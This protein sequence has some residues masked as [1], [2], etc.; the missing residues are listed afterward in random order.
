MT[1]EDALKASELISSVAELNDAAN[2]LIG[3]KPYGTVSFCQS[4]QR[5]S[6]PILKTSENDSKA[7]QEIEYKL[8]DAF[9]TF[10]VESIRILREKRDQLKTELENL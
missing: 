9:D 8:A 3:L 2:K 7:I 6:V 4:N 5:F 10:R 1:Q